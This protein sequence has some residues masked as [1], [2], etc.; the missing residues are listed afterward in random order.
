MFVRTKTGKVGFEEDWL[1]K[2]AMQ[3]SFSE[4]QGQ[5]SDP[6]LVL[7]S[8]NRLNLPLTVQV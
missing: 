7:K 5:R 4:D 1:K 6:K 3:C 8:L 2:Y